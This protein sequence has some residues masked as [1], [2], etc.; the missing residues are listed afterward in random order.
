MEPSV[1]RSDGVALAFEL[2]EMGVRLRLQRHRR[3]F[4]DA[5]PEDL[6]RLARAWYR[7]RPGAE[8]G[9]IAGSVRVRPDP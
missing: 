1:R 9:D 3:E 8:D 7:S 6:A 4:P 5:S 2:T